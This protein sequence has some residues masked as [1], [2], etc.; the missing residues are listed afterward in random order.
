MKKIWIIP[1]IPQV[2]KRLKAAAYCRVSTLGLAQCK[3][4]E[5]QI[6]TYVRII[7]NHPR[8]SF[9]GVFFDVGKSGLR[10]NGRIGLDKMLKK[11]GQGKI[12]YI[13]TKSISRV[14]KDTV[15]V[16]KII[17]QIDLRKNLY[18]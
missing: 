18:F 16:L 3:I 11:A 15:E 13:I 7:K 1:L 9:A 8:W 2:P 14:S 17:L 12:D 4:F 5:G 10:R 6:D